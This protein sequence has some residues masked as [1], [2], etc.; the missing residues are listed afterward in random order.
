MP[1]DVTATNGHRSRRSLIVTVLIVFVAT[2]VTLALGTIYD[3]GSYYATSVLVVIYA[4]VPFFVSFEQAKPSAHTVVI[5]AVLCALAVVARAAFFWI[6]YV[7]AI[8]AVIIIAGIGMGAQAGFMVG[9]L[10][11]FV[12]N[13]LFAQGPWTP[14]QMFSYGLTG[15]VFGLLAQKDVIPRS[16]L[17]RRQKVILAVTSFLF[18]LCITGPILD[19]SSVFM[20]LSTV[21]PEGALAVYATGLPVNAIHGLST[22]VILYLLANPLLDQL[23][24]IR[25]K[26]GLAA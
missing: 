18:V 22:A 23:A 6:P 2:P 26:Y 3:S 25:T 14:W 8:T 10:S 1:R 24:R 15:F 16:R 21:T 12:S 13:F 17:T 9:A 7:T 4:L 19:T 5:V 11:L 20:M